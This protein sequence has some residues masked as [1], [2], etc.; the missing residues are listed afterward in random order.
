MF[1][2]LNQHIKFG[3][4]FTAIEL[5]SSSSGIELQLLQIKKQKNSFEIQQS[6]VLKTVQEVA[7]K[8][9]PNQHVQ[10]IVNTDKVLSKTIAKEL[11][12][13]KAIR[14][15][16]PNINLNEFYYQVSQLAYKT[17]VSIV[18]K[19]AMD[20]W[21]K[22]FD[23]VKRAIIGISLSN[24]SATVLSLVSN[25]NLASSNAQLLFNESGLE[26]IQIE[27]ENKLPSSTFNLN[28]I[29]LT[30]KE[31]LGFAAILQSY[32]NQTNEASN[33]SNLNKQL[34]KN[35]TNN[36]LVIGGL[37]VGV[38]LLFIGLLINILIFD[39]LSKKNKQLS[40]SVALNKKYKE[41][42]LL[43]DT[44][45]S[46]KKKLANQILN[47]RS[48]KATYYLDEIGAEV[49]KSISLDILTFQPMLRKV[50]KNKQIVIQQD[51][52]VIEGAVLKNNDFS[53][54]VADLEKFNWINRVEV[55]NFGKEK[56]NTTFKIQIHL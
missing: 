18:R 39:S 10:L 16:F 32:L 29:Q 9:K 31:V 1:Q 40:Q 43:L 22:E 54:W 51:V 19:E 7:E 5:T 50:E 25:S 38:L 36:K 37:K 3:N 33:F 17:H 23:K 44:D 30:N 49:P 41:T 11:D 34:T 12:N 47:G 21:L 56:K 6:V 46:Q 28:G 27:K 52:I 8:V 15:A 2:R 4:S 42:Y 24:S 14:A 45:V 48:S 13:E 26:K 20:Y 35:Y 53:K 55:I